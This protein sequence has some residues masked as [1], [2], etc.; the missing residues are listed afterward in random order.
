MVESTA[1]I[2]KQR[3]ID[4]NWF[5]RSLNEPI[6]DKQTEKTSVQGTFGKG[7]LN[8]RHCLMKML[9]CRAWLMLI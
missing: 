7:A 6:A 8:H 5:M 1:D 3:L 2:Y 9:Y 4:V